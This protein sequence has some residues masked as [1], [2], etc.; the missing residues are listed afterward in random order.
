L[1]RKSPAKQSIVERDVAERERAR[2]RMANLLAELKIFEKI[3]RT[4]F[5][6]CAHKTH[7]FIGSCPARL[8]S[9][10]REPNA[11]L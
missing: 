4:R 3:A 7:S 6:G 8:F 11:S 2:C 10:N 1:H 9:Q 5:W